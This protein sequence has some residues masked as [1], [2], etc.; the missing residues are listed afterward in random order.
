MQALVGADRIERRI[1]R[2]VIAKPPDR[3]VGPL[4]R[5]IARRHRLLPSTA[6][7]LPRRDRAWPPPTPG[8]RDH[9]NRVQTRSALFAIPARDLGERGCTTDRSTPHAESA[10]YGRSPSVG[11]PASAASSRRTPSRGCRPSVP[12]AFPRQEG[13]DGGTFRFGAKLLYFAN[14]L[15][16]QHVGLEETDDGIWAIYFNTVLIA[17]LDEREYI[18]RG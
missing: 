6:E 5:A 15:T 9:G 11:A 3:R 7:Y 14:T 1:N 17:T 4:P 8:T 2:A 16:D 12:G 13:H 10:P 18:I